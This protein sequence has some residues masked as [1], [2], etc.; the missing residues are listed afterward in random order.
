MTSS[1]TSVPASGQAWG[2]RRQA[3]TWLRGEATTSVWLFR[4]GIGLLIVLAGVVWLWH[5]GA[6]SL[7]ADEALSWHESAHSLGRLITAVKLNELNP[8]GYFVFLHAW[9]KVAPS[10]SEFWLRVPSVIAGFG[11]VGALVWLTS[12]AAGRFAALLAG[13]VAVLSPYVFDYAQEARA[14]VFLMLAVTVAVAALLQAERSERGRGRWVAVSIVAAAVGMAAHYTTWLVALPLG[15]YLIVWSRLP[16][17]AKVIWVVGVAVSGL[18]WAPLLIEQWGAGHNTW[19]NTFANLDAQHFGDV[20]GAPFSGRIFQPEQRAAVGALIVLAGVVLAL[21]RSR[22]REIR[23]IVVLALACPVALLLASLAGHP[24]L[25][26]RY[27]AAAVPFMIA[28][29]AIAL[30]RLPVLPRAVLVAG[31]LGLAVW[32][33]NAAYQPRGHVM[34]IRGGLSYVR[35]SYHRGDVI[36]VVGGGNAVFL[37]GY[38]GPRLVPRGAQLVIMGT[39]RRL[40]DSPLAAALQSH[41]RIWVV[42]TDLPYS[43][44]LAPVGYAARRVRL[45]SGIRWLEVT[46]AQPRGRV[47]L[48]RPA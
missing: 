1:R 7:S 21:L 19:L 34:D 45:F 9:I 14:Y 10:T 25:L 27:T 36:A 44:R 13:L 37:L 41:R 6:S 48:R 18:V 26:S 15:V 38:Y 4:A 43:P 39:P 20:F 42:N 23:L 11:L 12:L 5:L 46:L 28:V 32:N 40:L 30:V 2:F 24:A 31:V 47:H 3:S 22:T 8:F 33:T 29:L 35:Q 16:K 17:R